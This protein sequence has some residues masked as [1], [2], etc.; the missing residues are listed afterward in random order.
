MASPLR[1]PKAECVE[2]T[3]F[4]VGAFSSAF[5]DRFTPELCHVVTQ[6]TDNPLSLSNAISS[7]LHAG[8]G[9]KGGDTQVSVG[10][11]HYEKGGD[12]L[13]TIVTQPRGEPLSAYTTGKKRFVESQASMYRVRALLRDI[14]EELVALH[15]VGIAHTDI[16]P[17]NIIRVAGANRLIDPGSMF[18]AR[19]SSRA[20]FHPALLTTPDYRPPWVGEGANDAPLD[21]SRLDVWS[22]GAT[23]LSLLSGEPFFALPRL[24][25]PSASHLLRR[26]KSVDYQAD[27]VRDAERRCSFVRC[28]LCL[29][30]PKR[31]DRIA[32][33]VRLVPLLAT[34]PSLAMLLSRMLEPREED[35][36]SAREALRTAEFLVDCAASEP[37]PELV[38][39][40]EST[41]SPEA[42]EGA[43]K[44]RRITAEARSLSLL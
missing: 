36:I 25:P 11:L 9:A 35:V 23:V 28:L 41:D 3:P 20:M 32:C 8:T 38:C 40:C 24:P 14:L 10:N 42:H 7:I 30:A 44:R 31:A 43:R 27:M 18:D 21:A 22:L 12:V 37:A 4:G 33:L 6:V 17:D 29:R 34:E 15:D 26:D 13:V 39:A 16:K 1:M 5:A 2:P 19:L